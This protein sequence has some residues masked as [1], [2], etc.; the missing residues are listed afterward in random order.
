MRGHMG[1]KELSPPH[2]PC[3]HLQ[4]GGR[5]VNPLQGGGGCDSLGIYSPFSSKGWIKTERSAET[6]PQR[7]GAAKSHLG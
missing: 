7:E 3:K 6:V 4:M 5:G 2:A 1:R